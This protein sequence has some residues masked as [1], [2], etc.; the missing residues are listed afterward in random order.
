MAN[1]AASLVLLAAAFCVAAVPMQPPALLHP[2][3]GYPGYS[4]FPAYIFGQNTTG[5]DNRA[6]LAAEARYS[7]AIFGWTTALH[8]LKPPQMHEERI[9]NEQCRQFSAARAP[10]PAVPCGTYR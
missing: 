3:W 10:A 4:R 7:M 2:P 9:L 1:A 5:L 6:Q 8:G